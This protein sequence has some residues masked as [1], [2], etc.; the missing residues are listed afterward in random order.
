M[1][2]NI[3]LQLLSLIAEELSFSPNRI[4]TTLQ[5]IMPFLHKEREKRNCISNYFEFI[6]PFYTD[7]EFIMHFRV[8]RSVYELL[9][10]RYINSNSMTG[11]PIQG[12]C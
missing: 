1:A 3:K 5:I 12:M 4:E 10:Q 9:V 2:E 6:I 7:R 11:K 8:A